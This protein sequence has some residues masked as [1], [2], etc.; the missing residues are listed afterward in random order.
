MKTFVLAL[1]RTGL[2]LAGLLNAALVLGPTPAGAATFSVSST[3]DSGAGSLRQAIDDANAT[4]GADTIVFNIPGE[5]PHTIAPLS[6][7]PDI[8]DPVTIDGYTQPGASPN[9]LAAGENAALSIVLSGSNG[10]AYGFF[11]SGGN[12]V[13]RGLVINQ[14]RGS[15]ILLLSGTNRVSGNF[16]G[17]DRDGLH[18]A[19]NDGDGVV[20]SGGDQNVIGGTDPAD[21]NLISGNGVAG[22]ALAGGGAHNVVQGNFIGTDASGTSAVGNLFFGVEFSDSPGNI[23]GGASAGAR[24][25]ISGNGQAGVCLFGTRGGNQVKG[26]YLGANVTGTSA[27]G[28]GTWGL[29]VLD[30]PG[31]V[32]GGPIPGAANLLA[33]NQLDG[34]AIDTASGDATGNAVLGNSIFANGG[35][36]IALSPS[37]VTPND[38]GDTDTGPNELQNFPDLLS[39]TAVGGGGVIQGALNSVANKAFRV[40]FFSND[41]PDPSGHGQGKTFLGA[42][43]I[44]TDGGGE[45]SFSIAFPAPFAIGQCLTATATDDANNTSEFSALAVAASL[46]S[47]SN[48][49]VLAGQTVVFQTDDLGDAVDYQ[50]SKDGGPLAGETTPSLT[51]S[52]VGIL[53]QGMYCVTVSGD[54]GSQT[55]CAFLT[56]TGVPP[57]LVCPSDM[58]VSND[59]DQCSAIASFAPGATGTPTPVVLCQPASGQSFPVGTNTV[60]CQA[61]N[62]AGTAT[63]SFRLIFRDTQPPT[64]ACPTP[65]VA[66]TDAGQCTKS[67]VTYAAV[68]TDNCP[69]ATVV[70]TP[71]SGSTF[72]KGVSTVSCIA[73]DAAGNTNGCSFTVTIN[74]LEPPAITCPAPILANTDGGQCSKSNI[75]DRKSTRLNS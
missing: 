32:I 49:T 63:C 72:A 44:T 15:A 39:A 33:C 68:I 69:D 34:V 13:I 24:N 52:N 16:I 27:L 70:C 4:A 40:E 60:T 20:I 7:L 64:I 11:I 36:G 42:A 3:L 29:Y 17:T 35:L 46:A 65:I 43:T 45:A 67:N 56:V 19:S 30:S 38:A 25:I 59:P 55:N 53:D 66:S 57:A 51:L 48:Q 6:L 26:N 5:G 58:I 10:V 21:R 75:T 41:A 1:L 28:N 50:W 22:G 14:F 74:D 37:G 73:T 12:S 23:I 62:F 2:V 61:S 54:F 31:N 47:L 18:P 71:S 8:I 9:T